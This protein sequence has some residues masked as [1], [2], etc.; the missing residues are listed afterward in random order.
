MTNPPLLTDS[1]IGKWIVFVTLSDSERLPRRT[2]AQY[3]GYTNETTVPEYVFSLRPLAGTTHIRVS[4]VL[5]LA[6]VG[7]SQSPSYGALRDEQ[8]GACKEGYDKAVSQDGVHQGTAGWQGLRHLCRG[9]S[10]QMVLR[11][12]PR[13]SHPLA[14]RGSH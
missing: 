13:Q 3:L 11:R 8:G 6:R 1:E 9:C 10:T 12:V 2:T 14:I 5:K 4:E 7:R